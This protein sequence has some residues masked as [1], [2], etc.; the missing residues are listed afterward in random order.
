VNAIK[1]VYVKEASSKKKEGK[2]VQKGYLDSLI[3]KKKQEIS[4]D[5]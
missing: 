5:D 3:N 2:R 4:V 1:E